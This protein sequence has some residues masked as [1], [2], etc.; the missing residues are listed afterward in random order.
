MPDSIQKNIMNH[1]FYICSESILIT[2]CALHGNTFLIEIILK[3]L[4]KLMNTYDTYEK[5][6]KIFLTLRVN[7]FFSFLTFRATQLHSFYYRFDVVSCFGI[8][9]FYTIHYEPISMSLNILLYYYIQRMFSFCDMEFPTL[10]PISM[11]LE[12][13]LF[14]VF[15]S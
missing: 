12:V 5:Q 14:Q 13:Y 15:S 6:K 11:W 4:M 10:H 3:I 9:F 8:L 2:F 1:Q 7:T